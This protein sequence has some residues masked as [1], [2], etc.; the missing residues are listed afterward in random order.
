MHVLVFYTLLR[1]NLASSQYVLSSVRMGQGKNENK[2]LAT[3]LR[4]R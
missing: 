3:G 2:F 1:G 4:S